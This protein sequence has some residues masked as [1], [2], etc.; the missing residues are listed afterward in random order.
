[1]DSVAALASPTILTQMQTRRL[2]DLADLFASA[3]LEWIGH[4]WPAKHWGVLDSWITAVVELTGLDPA[5][6][7][8]QAALVVDEMDQGEDTDHIP[9]DHGTLLR[10]EQWSR[11][12]DPSG[13]LAALVNAIGILP[14]Q[15]NQQLM[16]AIATTLDKARA[17]ELL[18]TELDRLAIWGRIAAG[19]ILLACAQDLDADN[20]A[21]TWLDADDPFLRT[22]AAH[23][24]SIKGSVDQ[25]APGPELEQCLKD[26]DENVRD[27]ALWALEGDLSSAMRE[28]LATLRSAPR[29]PW[30]C[31]W[32]GEVNPAT[33]G[34]S[35]QRCST[36]G[37]EVVMHID[38]LLGEQRQARGQRRVLTR[39]RR[40]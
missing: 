1:L 13:T 28:R 33:Q 16:I 2:D 29:Q 32:C 38:E 34:A 8:A 19:R 36:V 31:R 18:E 4:R 26:P 25:D 5:I 39:G 24:W 7:A 11:V 27:A 23:W 15:A 10:P 21:R 6:L 3:C 20:R 14:Y 40:A 9:Y 37:P 30:Q 12:E 22:A 17:I 35:C